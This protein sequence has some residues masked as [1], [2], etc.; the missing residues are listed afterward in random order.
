MVLK[1]LRESPITEGVDFLI[2][3]KSKDS[4][5]TMYITGPYIVADEVN[6]NNR[7]YPLNEVVQEVDRYK[8]E[9]IANRRSLGELE[10]PN[11]ASVNAERACHMITELRQDGN[12]FVGK[13]K[14]L[15]S[16]MGLIVRSLILDGVKLGMSSRALGKLNEVNGHNH[17]SGLRLVTVDCVADPSA[18]GAFVNGILE[19]KQ[20][21]LKTD[22]TLEECYDVFEKSISTLPRSDVDSYL[23]DHIMQFILKINN[24]KA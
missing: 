1:L 10:H 4:P 14:V 9:I 18:P 23:R 3:E 8:K 24:R 7:V 22:G 21:V 5:S 11:T 13:S 2:E 15:S 20:Y 17:V 6:K 16:P 12:V 19:S